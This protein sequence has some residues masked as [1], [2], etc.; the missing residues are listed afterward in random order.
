MRQAGSGKGKK[1]KEL[2]PVGSQEELMDHEY[3]F[4]AAWFPIGVPIRKPSSG[5]TF[6]AMLFQKKHKLFGKVES[7]WKGQ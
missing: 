7:D 3:D 6:E 1:E 5:E 4:R 2:V